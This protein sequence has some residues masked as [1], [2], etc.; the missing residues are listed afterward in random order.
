MCLPFHLAGASVPQSGAIVELGPLAGFS[1]KCL[2]TGIK[3]TGPGRKNS[4]IVYDSHNGV[5]NY[6]TLSKFEWNS[7]IAKLTVQ[8]MLLFDRINNQDIQ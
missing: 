3:S 4:M 2:A 7:E 6:N 8:V 5:M 1:S